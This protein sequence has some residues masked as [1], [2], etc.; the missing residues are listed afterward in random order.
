MQCTAA[1]TYKLMYVI[2]SAPRAVSLSLSLSPSLFPSCPHTNIP[3]SSILSCLT[4]FNRLLYHKTAVVLCDPWGAPRISYT[5]YRQYLKSPCAWKLGS[6]IHPYRRKYSHFIYSAEHMT[7]SWE[8]QINHL[9]FA[10]P[11]CVFSAVSR[12]CKSFDACL[13]NKLHCCFHWTVTYWR[14]IVN[15]HTV[16][17][18]ESAREDVKT[19]ALVWEREIIRVVFF[20]IRGQYTFNSLSSVHLCIFTLRC[21]S[22]FFASPCNTAALGKHGHSSW[23]LF[24]SQ[25]HKY[26]DFLFSVLL[27][28]RRR[29]S[30]TRSLGTGVW[31]LLF[32]PSALKSLLEGISLH[33]PCPTLQS[34]AKCV[35]MPSCLQFRKSQI[36][37]ILRWEEGK[38]EKGERAR[39]W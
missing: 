4:F 7:M 35:M 38:K 37:S 3:G 2:P 9:V 27:K 11:A 32:S 24:E 5:T 21:V 29:P 30:N 17:C 1:Q 36:H 6:P 23:P 12:Q 39:V 22:V 18:M 8:A 26:G 20:C 19:N 15:I 34:S 25:V 31:D 16:I 33:F 14:S 10:I 13:L 28:K